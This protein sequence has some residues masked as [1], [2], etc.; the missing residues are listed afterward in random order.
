MDKSIHVKKAM[1]SVI[2]TSAMENM[3]SSKKASIIHK[4]Y[5]VGKIDNEE[6]IK[7]IKEIYSL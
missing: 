3:K 5:L 1:A 6:A 4:L 2:A 7:R